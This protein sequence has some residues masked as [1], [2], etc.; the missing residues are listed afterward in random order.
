LLNPEVDYS[1]AVKEIAKAVEKKY[2]QFRTNL[3]NPDS[4]VK[5]IVNEMKKFHQTIQK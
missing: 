3:K 2:A 4:L 1:E 5:I